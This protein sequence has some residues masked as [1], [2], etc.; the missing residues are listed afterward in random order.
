MK[1]V[2]N[3]QE[4]LRNWA[5]D[6]N[7]RSAVE[8]TIHQLLEGTQKIA[9]IASLGSLAGDL[10]NEAGSTNEDGDSQK[11]LDVKSH[12]ILLEACIES[13]VAVL[14]SEEAAEVIELNKTAPLAVV[15]DPLDG[16]SNI[17][18][19]APIGT[20]FSIYAMP[21]AEGST[22]E[23]AVLQ[24][25]DNQL[26]A[27]YVIYGTQ[28]ALVLTL[29]EG[30]HIFILNQKV[31]EYFLARKSIQIPH[32]A[33]EYAINASNFGFWDPSIQNYVQDCIMGYSDHK[34]KFNMRW[35][36]SL[37]AEAHR[38]FYRGGIFLYPRDSREGY[39]FGRLRLV[40]EANAMAFL[41]EQAGGAAT[42]CVQRI[43]EIKPVSLHQRIPLAMGSK[44]NVSMVA[45][46]QKFK[47]DESSVQAPLFG[48]RGLF[49]SDRGSY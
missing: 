15:I 6:D 7:T 44:T 34:Q 17:E 20:I 3:I 45:E 8:K 21:Q 19:N 42:D 32:S 4:Y 25:G 24:A 29:G 16:S 26:A 40:Y 22:A 2:E 27:A 35:V 9:E 11:L 18:T 28:T 47:E 23:D 1:Q 38:I 12:E 33:K 41:M 39:Q 14:G 37:V 10:A 43:M 30:T 49:S 46:Y 48:T 13:P 31:G 5:G 36:A